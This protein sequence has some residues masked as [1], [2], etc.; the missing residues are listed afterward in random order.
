MYFSLSELQ[1]K[2]NEELISLVMFLDKSLELAW[3]N[4]NSLI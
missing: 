3:K 2:S 1:N 4:L